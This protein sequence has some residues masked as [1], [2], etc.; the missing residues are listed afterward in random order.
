[1]K[2]TITK[3]DEHI[4]EVII[5][6]MITT[7]HKVTKDNDSLLFKRKNISAEKINSFIILFYIK[8]RK[9]Y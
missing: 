7:I 2:K 6:T 3:L 1:M 5:E 8:K 9:K 4:C